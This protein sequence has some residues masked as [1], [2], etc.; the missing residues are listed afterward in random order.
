MFSCARNV[1]IEYSIPTCVDASSA[2]PSY[3]NPSLQ[4]QHT[5]SSGT[6]AGAVANYSPPSLWI[7]LYKSFVASEK[8]IYIAGWSVFCK[9]KLLRYA[10]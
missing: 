9:I 3:Y 7:D 10:N 2:D 5:A 1:D 8:F 4:Q 6:N